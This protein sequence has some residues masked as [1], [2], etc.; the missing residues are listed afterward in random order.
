MSFFLFT[1]TDN[2][3]AKPVP[4]WGVGSSGRE[5]DIRKGYRRVKMVG[6]YVRIC[7]W[8]NER[9]LLKLFQEWGKGD[10]EECWRGE[11][12]YDIL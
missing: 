12:K 6:Y 10:K 3:K 5:E 1:K 7:K 2:S 8:K 11:F 9:D 4:V